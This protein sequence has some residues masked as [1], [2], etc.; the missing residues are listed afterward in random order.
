MRL[1]FSLL[2]FALAWMQISVR[3]AQAEEEETIVRLANSFMSNDAHVLRQTY[4]AFKN[5][6]PVENRL[7]VLSKIFEYSTRLQNLSDGLRTRTG[8][9]A[10]LDN[11]RI[12]D[13][14]KCAE[15]EAQ[16]Y[17]GFTD[18]QDKLRANVLF[19]IWRSYAYS[20]DRLRPLM[21]VYL[22]D[23]SDGIRAD[24]LRSMNGFTDFDRIFTY[25]IHQ[26][27][28]DKA[29]ASSMAGAKKFREKHEEYQIATIA[30]DS[31][32][33]SEFSDSLSQDD[34]LKRRE[35]QKKFD[36]KVPGEGRLITLSRIWVVSEHAVTRAKIRVGVLRYL[37]E[38]KL[39]NW[40]KCMELECDIYGGFSAPEDIVRQAVFDLICVSFSQS[41]ESLRPLLLIFLNDP[42]DEL[43]AS[44]LEKFAKLQNDD[45]VLDLYLRE[46][47]AD[48]KYAKSIASAKNILDVSRKQKATEK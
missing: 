14:H 34:A 38:Q 4:K 16:I 11:E 37:K 23:Q 45:K 48:A 24:A 40:H 10:F 39:L 7:N 19:L 25:Y 2:P 22:G 33:L 9:V 1:L 3:I 18:R 26:H 17:R 32:L 12:Y 15:L 41:E 30:A 44:A 31:K 21:L 47:E 42:N 43:R 6:I 27:E 35:A 13:W 28:G 36:E 29:Y 46:H 8:V 20:Q 5:E